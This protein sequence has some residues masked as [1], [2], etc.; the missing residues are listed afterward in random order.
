MTQIEMKNDAN[1]QKC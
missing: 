1:Q